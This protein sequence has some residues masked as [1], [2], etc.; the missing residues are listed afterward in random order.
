MSERRLQ[1]DFTDPAQTAAFCVYQ[2][3]DATRYDFVLAKLPRS[4]PGNFMVCW[5]N[6]RWPH[7]GH[8]MTFQNEGGPDEVGYVMEKMGWEGP[9]GKYDAGMVIQFLHE[10]LPAFL[11]VGAK[12]GA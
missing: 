10:A 2:P 8:C 7:K 11:S 5:L 9:N 6:P 1:I 12:V 4:A 3:G